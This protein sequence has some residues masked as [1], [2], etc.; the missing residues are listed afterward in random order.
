[1]SDRLAALYV[2]RGTCFVTTMNRSADGFWF[3]SE[4]VFVEDG[5][6]VTVLSARI[7]QALAASRSNVP[8]PPRNE[9]GSRLPG[10]A[11][12]KSYGAFMKG[13]VRVSI[14]SDGDEIK[15]TPMRNG[16]PRKGFEPKSEE[17]V[18]VENADSLAIS[19]AAV[20]A[21]AE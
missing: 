9:L 13:S 8:T 11:G 3:E 5:V 18:I 16:G 6:D 21:A 12:V 4:P 15:L 7:Q 1:M 2:R 14:L 10:L 17:V 19:L 20:M